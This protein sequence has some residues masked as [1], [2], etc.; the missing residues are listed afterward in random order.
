M[1]ARTTFSGLVGALLGIALVSPLGIH[2]GVAA[3]QSTQ[4][5]PPTS[6]AASHRASTFEEFVDAT[7]VQERRLAKLMRNFKPIVE[8]YIQ[9]QKTDPDDQT[10][11][12][13]DFYFLSRIR[14]AANELYVREF[15]SREHAKPDR[16]KLLT[17]VKPEVFTAAD[18][19]QPIFPDL[20]HFDRE[21]YEFKLVRWEMVNEVRCIVIDVTP[22]EG[23]DNR[24]FIGRIWVE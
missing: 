21:N 15:E 18:F 24:A 19:A 13:E 8:T 9:K 5:P 14:L 11:P 17:R 23:S 1:Y 7:I 12:K 22:R 4:N 3:A 2:N 20:G 16:K 10:S 6:A